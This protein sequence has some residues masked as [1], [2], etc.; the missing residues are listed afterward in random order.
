M[1]TT[2]EQADSNNFWIERAVKAQP[3]R[4]RHNL[5]CTCASCSGKGMSLSAQ[6]DW[7]NRSGGQRAI[8]SPD[9]ERDRVAVQKAECY[10]RMVADVK[11]NEAFWHEQRGGV[12]L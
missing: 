11:A 4:D 3:K 9:V 10:Q 6:R 5:N 2:Q 1:K 7:F 12:M 8:V